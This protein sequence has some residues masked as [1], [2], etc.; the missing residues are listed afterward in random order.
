MPTIENTPLSVPTGLA[1]QVQCYVSL[2]HTAPPHAGTGCGSVLSTL[3]FCHIAR[4]SPFKKKKM[5][6]V[7]E[8]FKI[9]PLCKYHTIKELL[10]ML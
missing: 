7:K 1:Q 2:V 4:P 5:E 6:I 8:T 10:S 3:I 9:F